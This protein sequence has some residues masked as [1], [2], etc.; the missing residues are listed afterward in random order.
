MAKVDSMPAAVLRWVTVPLSYSY[1]EMKDFKTNQ[2]WQLIGVTRKGQVSW[3]NKDV[4]LSQWELCPRTLTSKHFGVEGN[5]CGKKWKSIE[6][7]L[8][9]ALRGIPA[10][11]AGKELGWSWLLKP[12]I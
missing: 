6:N 2:L 8:A 5:Q 3:L 11:A 4:Q 9:T 7:A 10:A 1:M 12:E